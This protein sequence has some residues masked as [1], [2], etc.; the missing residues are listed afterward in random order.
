MTDKAAQLARIDDLH[1]RLRETVERFPFPEPYEAR[2]AHADEIMEYR[3]AVHRLVLLAKRL[4]HSRDTAN[5]LLERGAV[6]QLSDL[7][8]RDLNR[9]ERILNGDEDLEL[10]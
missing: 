3:A 6:Q 8:V 4:K 2:R 9:L 5:E 1:A 7:P 10:V